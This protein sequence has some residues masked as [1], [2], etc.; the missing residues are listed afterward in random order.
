M[1]RL[2]PL[3]LVVLLVVGNA[4]GEEFKSI[5]WIGKTE[6][7]SEERAV[8]S[9]AESGKVCEMYGHNWKMDTGCG[10]EPL[11]DDVFCISTSAKERICKLCHLKQVWHE[12]W[13]DEKETQ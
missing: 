13:V 11:P 9:L 12:E 3:V 6:T 5:G 2:I 1:T 10:Y 8:K 7:E 4:W